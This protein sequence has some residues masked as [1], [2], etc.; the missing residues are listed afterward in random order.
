[1]V[2]I[3]V[4]FLIGDTTDDCFHFFF[5]IFFVM[6]HLTSGLENDKL[7]VETSTK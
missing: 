6:S 5:D 1:M 7:S 4:E 3:S 2:E